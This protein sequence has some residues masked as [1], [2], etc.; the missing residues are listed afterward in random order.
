M[1]K[2]PIMKVN[3]MIIMMI[4]LYKGTFL[5]TIVVTMLEIFIT[6]K[7]ILVAAM[8]ITC[9]RRI[10]RK[11]YLKATGQKNTMSHKLKRNKAVMKTLKGVDVDETFKSID[12]YETS[13]V[14]SVVVESILHGEKSNFTH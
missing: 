11:I 10:S 12:V 4:F 7:Q 6:T 1:V 3:L 2:V 13:I 14:S 8:I 9:Q 5:P